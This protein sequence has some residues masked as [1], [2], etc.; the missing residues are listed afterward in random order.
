M[1]VQA[2]TPAWQTP[3]PP[4]QSWPPSPSAAAVCEELTAKLGSGL[5]EVRDRAL[6]TLASKVDGGLV[7]LEALARIRGL[8]QRLLLWI[9]DR[10]AEAPPEL[11]RLCLR[12]LAALAQEPLAAASLQQAGCVRFLEDF[13]VGAVDF[14]AEIQLALQALLS[15]PVQSEAAQ[16]WQSGD[17]PPP[18]SWS[19][20]SALRSPLVG[21][22]RAAAATPQVRP[23]SALRDAQG[24]FRPATPVHMH[25]ASPPQLARCAEMPKAHGGTV[26]PQVDTHELMSQSSNFGTEFVSHMMFEPLG[27]VDAQVLM[28]ISVRIR[29]GDAS[30]LQAACADLCEVA[31]NFP[32]VFVA[33]HGPLV[34]ALCHALRVCACGSGSRHCVR[35]VLGAMHAMVARLVIESAPPYADSFRGAWRGAAL[36]V[37]AEGQAS[38]LLTPLYCLL[39]EVL[40]SGLQEPATAA[41]AHR[42]FEALLRLCRGSSGS[43]SSTPALGERHCGFSRL[44]ASQ[45]ALLLRLAAQL[46]EAHLASARQQVPSLV[47]ALRWLEGGPRAGRPTAGEGAGPW[48]EPLITHEWSLHT[49]LLFDIFLVVLQAVSKR[50][51][52]ELAGQFANLESLVCT[53]LFDYRLLIERPLCVGTL[54]EYVAAV[55]EDDAAHFETFR[56]LVDAA[57]DSAAAWTGGILPGSDAERLLRQLPRLESRLK[58][59][60]LNDDSMLPKDLAANAVGLVADVAHECREGADDALNHHLRERCASLCCCLATCPHEATQDQFF[61][62]LES[63]PSADWI[64]RRRDFLAACLLS[65]SPRAHESIVRWRQGDCEAPARGAAAPDGAV[66]EFIEAACL[67][68]APTSLASDLRRLF[69]LQ[70]RTREAA[71]LLIWR[72][73]IASGRLDSK[74]HFEFVADPVGSIAEEGRSVLRGY[75]VNGLKASAS[76]FEH[77]H[78]IFG[79][80]RL[81]WE[82]RSASLVQ[83]TTFVASSTARSLDLLREA[84]RSVA[85]TLIN[86]LRST[87]LPPADAKDA[88]AACD[89]LSMLCHAAV[90]LLVAVGG[91]ARTSLAEGTA[92]LPG[93]QGAE[94]CAAGPLLAHRDAVLDMLIP[95]MFHFSSRLRAAVLQLASCLLFGSAAFGSIAAKPASSGTSTGALPDDGHPFRLRVAPWLLD[96]FGLPVDSDAGEVEPLPAMFFWTR[97]PKSSAVALSQIFH[98][99]G[100]RPGIA[101]GTQAPSSDGDGGAS[102]VI[103]EIEG[104]LRSECGDA[105]VS[106]AGSVAIVSPLGDCLLR[107]A[108]FLPRLMGGVPRPPTSVAH[109]LGPAPARRAES[110]TKLVGISEVLLAVVQ[111]LPPGSRV[112]DRGALG[113]QLV[114]AL[115][116][117][118]MPDVQALVIGDVVDRETSSRRAQGTIAAEPN[119]RRAAELFLRLCLAVAQHQQ[120]GTQWLSSPRWPPLLAALLSCCGP[121]VRRLTLG[122]VFFVLPASM[123]RLPHALE[124]GRLPSES[125]QVL[126]VAL[127]ETLGTSAAASGSLMHSFELKVVLWLLGRMAAMD[128]HD[129]WDRVGSAEVLSCISPWLSHV[130]VYVQAMGWRALSLFLR[131]LCRPEA[132]GASGVAAGGNSTH[133]AAVVSRALRALRAHGGA[134]SRA[135]VHAEVFELV[136]VAL[137]SVAEEASQREVYVRQVVE[138]GLLTGDV[139]RAALAPGE[140]PGLR[141]AALRFVRAVLEADFATVNGLLVHAGLW[142]LLT[143]AACSTA[144]GRLPGRDGV[145]SGD[146]AGGDERP[147][148]LDSIIDSATVMGDVVAMVGLVAKR[149]PQMLLWLSAS[150]ELL[151]DWQ[152]CLAE[153]A[154]HLRRSTVMSVRAARVLTSH[155]SALHAVLTALCLQTSDDADGSGCRHWLPI[156]AFVASAA[157]RAA[158]SEGLRPT[159]PPEARRMAAAVVAALFGLALAGGGGG[160]AAVVDLGDETDTDK[161]L[162]ESAC[163]LFRAV[164]ACSGE[165][166]SKQ[167]LPMTVCCCL[168]NLFS[169]STAAAGAAWKAGFLPVLSK[170]ITSLGASRTTEQ[171]ALSQHLVWALRI[172]AALLASCPEAFGA[173]LCGVAGASGGGAEQVPPLASV[174]LALRAPCDKD[175][176]ICLEVLQMISVCMQA[177]ED[178]SS[179]DGIREGVAALLLRLEFVQWLM[180]LSQKKGIATPV[181]CKVMGLLACCAPQLSGKPVLLRFLAQLAEGLRTAL[182]GPS[183]AG[184]AAGEEA[185]LRRLVATLN[186]VASLRLCA[187]SAAVLVGP[188]QSVHTVATTGSDQVGGLGMDGWLDVVEAEG[189]PPSSPA[190]APVPLHHHELR[191][192][193]LRG[194]LAVAT[195]SAPQGKA[196]FVGSP[197][198]VP[199][200]LRLVRRGRAPLPSLALNILWVLAHGAQR[201]LPLLRR[202]RAAE[203][204]REALEAAREVSS[205][206]DE[207]AQH[208][209]FVAEQMCIILG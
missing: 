113:Q 100:F 105:L 138:A 122:L 192:A 50:D 116:D 38:P 190:A 91:S 126:P 141:R 18:L 8:P 200:L 183:A 32:A 87:S 55:C 187:R 104:R 84:P 204:V 203:V 5:G 101:I 14:R 102:F 24:D 36:P 195:S 71:A 132:A 73:Q 76:D 127:L 161:V 140:H 156:S 157:A 29:Y 51:F 176:T 137:E 202:L 59:A 33:S 34:D 120:L 99:I 133:R 94:A 207:E 172:L 139:L 196:Y 40:R 11:V 191:A 193:A 150:T 39:V 74:G 56:D 128:D 46:L 149:D 26:C 206:E 1:L 198:A 107:D 28:D 155:L 93:Q 70:A 16:T 81:G 121:S 112:V 67:E 152:E 186:F 19:E 119:T 180:R 10:Q 189:R 168:V 199:L 194:L 177:E 20:P 43:S 124:D 148:R 170:T 109:A 160:G 175:D 146:V 53:L 31:C 151:G 23:S 167:P 63:E 97:I 147:P 118:L 6:R 108:S 158:A 57:C 144:S 35:D 131:R 174:L 65:A 173:A 42:A 22:V 85:L 114:E 83:F 142:P 153:L 52:S 117:Q 37:A 89:F 80:E 88:K 111:A 44:H 86:F 25:S 162:S 75:A 115:C 54:L 17:A 143:A 201:A 159:S 49:L 68:V 47:A 179:D 7:P 41:T 4:R 21:Q 169:A 110:A 69:A 129:F 96:R 64:Y 182:R 188:E 164:A 205:V 165:L 95:L 125:L 197:R 82:V 15:H 134:A 166:D 30:T 66:L 77:L 61:R 98:R 92:T 48:A 185:R 78:G 135:L 181:Y 163:E 62:M 2:M 13:H 27:E 79:N 90:A 45:V 103:G 58:L 145:A 136:R 12:F 72:A 208:F 3:S 123:L 209:V 60:T 171:R 106:A 130:D 154:M 184:A 178:H 9:N